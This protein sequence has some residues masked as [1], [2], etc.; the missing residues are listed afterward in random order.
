M[1]KV[2]Y[3]ILA[4]LVCFILFTLL[5]VTGIGIFFLALY[6]NTVIVSVWKYITG[7]ADKKDKKEEN[8][9]QE[10]LDDII[11][12]D[13]EESGINDYD[14]V[15]NHD[16]IDNIEIV[17][18]VEGKSEINNQLE[19]ISLVQMRKDS[20][21]ENIEPEKLSKK[22]KYV[23]VI[24]LSLIFFFGIA[25]TIY[26]IYQKKQVAKK[27]ETI[28]TYYKKSKKA[29]EENIYVL[30][31]EYLDKII[32]IDSTFSDAYRIKGEIFMKQEQYDEAIAYFQKV[33]SIKSDS[34]RAYER[35]GEAYHNKKNYSQALLCY[36][37]AIGIKPDTVDIYNSIGFTYIIMG[38]Y[39][40]AE[41]YLKKA[42]S[43]EQDN[44]TAWVYCG[45]LCA[46]QK[47]YE[48]AL[49]YFEKAI[50]ICPNDGMIY[51]NMAH[52]YYLMG[53]YIK[54][55]E[56]YKKAAQLGNKWGQN[57]LRKNGYDW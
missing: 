48:G 45:I 38:N 36:Q 46:E 10:T 2:F 15:E 42:L 1:R 4:S 13:I 12:D 8:V 33:I 52:T 11:N 32:E 5:F 24:S 40:Q 16:N 57:W 29:Y 18:L 17:S 43:I 55:I 41:T 53:N 35:M 3:Y 14:E 28:D 23:W 21:N 31:H 20:I 39:S 51:T 34:Y 27:K 54:R 44:C 37:K 6:W 9:K 47:Q 22:P 25:G 50:S 30:A 49:N 7:L 26:W 56:Y 19:E